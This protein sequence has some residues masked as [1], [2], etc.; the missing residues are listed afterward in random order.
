VHASATQPDSPSTTSSRIPPL[1]ET[2]TGRPLAI[3]SMQL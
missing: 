2:I 1:G 3:A